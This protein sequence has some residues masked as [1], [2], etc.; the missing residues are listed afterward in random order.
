MGGVGAC[1][2]LDLQPGAKSILAAVFKQPTPT[3]AVTLA[4]DEY[5]PDKRYRGLR[6]LNRAPFAGEDVYVELFVDSMDEPDARVRA[7]AAAAIANHG[8]PRHVPLLVKALK[9]K[10]PI[11]RI[12]AVRG[13]QRIHNPVAVDPLLE[14]I[15]RADEPDSSIRAEAANA[16]G[17][18]PERRVAQALIATLA[19]RSLAVNLNALQSLRTLTGEDFGMDRAAWTRWLDDQKDP[20]AHRRAYIYPVFHRERRWLEYIPF[21]PEP[22][23]EVASSPVG[24][25]PTPGRA[26]G[27]P[28][29]AGG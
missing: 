4:V 14:T 9:D 3:E 26:A 18:Y 17:Q 16:L 24:I 8:E 22:P 21:F 2:H 28:P 12:E 13:L 19:E 1:G 6:L 25:E 23:N 5:D 7:A 10:D 29:G 27:E 11:V 15:K 20:F